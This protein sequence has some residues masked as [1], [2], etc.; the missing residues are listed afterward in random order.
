MQAIDRWIDLYDFSTLVLRKADWDELD[1][2]SRVL[3]VC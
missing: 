1:E 3:D 2:I